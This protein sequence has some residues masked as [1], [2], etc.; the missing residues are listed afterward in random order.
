MTTNLRFGFSRVSGIWIQ[1]SFEANPSLNTPVIPAF[2]NRLMGLES[3]STSHLEDKLNS[4]SKLFKMQTFD[5]IDGIELEI[6]AA[7]A[8]RPAHAVVMVPVSSVLSLIPALLACFPWSRVCTCM[9]TRVGAFASER[10]DVGISLMSIDRRR[11]A[12]VPSSHQI[13]QTLHT[14]SFSLFTDQ[15]II[16]IHTASGR[17][18]RMLPHR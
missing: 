11:Q 10:P 17:S 8:R 4:L 5:E 18:L 12:N 15:S 9:N 13:N 16:Y 7:C 3:A 1:S 2:N 14:S 6:C